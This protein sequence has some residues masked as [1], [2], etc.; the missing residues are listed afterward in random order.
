M[1]VALK[2][3]NNN[4]RQFLISSG[5]F[6]AGTTVLG[7]NLF[8]K[9]LRKLEGLFIEKEVSPAEDLMRERGIL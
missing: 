8:G 4:R 6:I 7:N 3:F 9:T 5:I 1:R 2:D